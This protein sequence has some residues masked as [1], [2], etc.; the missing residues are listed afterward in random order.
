MRQLS[1]YL[2]STIEVK[3]FVH[4]KVEVFLLFTNFN[5]TIRKTAMKHFLNMQI[6]LSRILLDLTTG[7]V[8]AAYIIKW[9]VLYIPSHCLSTSV[10]KKL[11]TL[12]RSAA[13]EYLQF[14]R[15]RVLVPG[16]HKTMIATYL[17]VNVVVYSLWQLNMCKFQK[18]LWRIKDV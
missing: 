15:N 13:F 4:G 5:G 14:T 2:F 3:I 7:N 9:C 11:L 18:L 8:L 16:T 12:S 6:I 1:K 10:L 17:L